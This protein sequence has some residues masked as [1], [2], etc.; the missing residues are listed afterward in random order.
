MRPN[1]FNGKLIVFSGIDGSGK[2]TQSKILHK[3]FSNIDISSILAFE[4]TNLPI[5][6]FIRETILQNKQHYDPSQEALLFAAD[7]ILHQNNIVIPA[8][9]R[10]VHVILDR[11]IFASLSYQ[12]ARGVDIDLIWRLNSFVIAPD[13]AFLLDIPPEVGLNRKRS[14]LDWF[15]EQLELQKTVRAFYL[16]LVEQ[17]HLIL[18]NATPHPRKIHEEIIEQ[19]LARKIIRLRA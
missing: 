17:G 15:E 9:K 16:Q 19:L 7:R 14:Q 4:P 5:G 2:T 1:S 10:N 6:N 18:I 12:H 11:Y 3:F 8:L 13:I